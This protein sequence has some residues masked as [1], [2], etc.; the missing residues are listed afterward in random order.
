MGKQT[1]RKAQ[2]QA[3]HAKASR[4]KL[5]R[6]GGLGGIILIA[7]IALVSWRNA[8]VTPDGETAVFAG[9]LLDGPA[10]APIKVVEYADLTCSACR[11][12]HNLGIKE[13]LR[14]D[15][16]NQISFEYRHFPVITASSP[17]GAQAAQCAAEQDGFL[18]FH[19]YI[20]ENLEPYPNLNPA[21]VQ[22]IA[23]TI[24]LD[25]EAFDS[26]LDS[27][28]YRAFVTEAIERAQQDGV[29]GTPTFFIN[30]QPVFPS[31]EAMAATINDLL[32][33]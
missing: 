14:A 26:C 13:Q 1:S 17:N 4:L 7:F 10:D 27:G 5:L 2:R 22:E 18:P 28:R 32:A 6:Y 8:D 3:A 23:S 21:R 11:Q 15:F 12:W 29:R 24:G 31:Y 19:D 33:N 16:G 9:P 30:D 25:R 20:Y